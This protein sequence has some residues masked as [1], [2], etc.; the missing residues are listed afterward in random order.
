[1][2]IL[3][4]LCHRVGSSALLLFTIFNKCWLTH[5]TTPIGKFCLSKHQ[6]IDGILPK[7]HIINLDLR[8]K[9]NNPELF[10][11][12]RNLNQSAPGIIHKQPINNTLKTVN[13]SCL[14][15]NR[16]AD[17]RLCFN[18]TDSTLFFLNPKFQASSLLLWLCRLI[19]VRP[20]R[21]PHC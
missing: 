4:K 9:I 1:M 14:I 19:C 21:K 18:Y 15:G 7:M 17:Q 6:R 8:N 16:E 3:I 13:L 5:D 20:V 2:K 10:A 12:K 11:N